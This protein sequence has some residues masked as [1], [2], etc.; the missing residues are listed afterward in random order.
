MSW[1]RCGTSWTARGTF[2]ARRLDELKGAQGGDGSSQFSL[3]DF[4]PLVPSFGASTMVC[5]D[6][7]EKAPIPLVAV[8]AVSTVTRLEAIAIRLETIVMR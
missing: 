6:D 5:V 3:L 8:G 7:G 2:N 1:S 4:V